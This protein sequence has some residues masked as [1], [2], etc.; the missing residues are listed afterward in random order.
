MSSVW[1][2]LASLDLQ[3]VFVFLVGMSAVE[4]LAAIWA[5]TGPGHWFWRALGVWAAFL[6]LIPIRAWEPAW[7]FI[8]A[9]PLI[10]ATIVCATWLVRPRNEMHRPKAV[11]R[12]TVRDLLALVLIVSLWLSVLL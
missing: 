11:W 1:Q 5:A 3:R 12:F 8:L 4:C 6:L 10:I 2:Q 9:A 7:M